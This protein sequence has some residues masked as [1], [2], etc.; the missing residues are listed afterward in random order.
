MSMGELK[1]IFD[2]L[3]D[4][5]T[6]VDTLEEGWF[7]WPDCSSDIFNVT[8][9]EPEPDVGFGGG[10]ESFDIH[11][12]VGVSDK[13]FTTVADAARH[14]YSLVGDQM[15]EDEAMLAEMLS[16]AVDNALADMEPDHG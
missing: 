8:W 10:P 6:P 2:L 15:V 12:W 4:N 1:G 14:L 9:A 16:N 11:L 13:P 5:L 7:G 3:P